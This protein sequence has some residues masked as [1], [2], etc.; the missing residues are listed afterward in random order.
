[1]NT[2][3]IDRITG[4]IA[5]MKKYD[6]GWTY[7]DK[8]YISFFYEIRKHKLQ[9]FNHPYLVRKNFPYMGSVFWERAR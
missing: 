5:H 4:D 9:G 3:I 7:L 8:R 6:D 1:M 2:D